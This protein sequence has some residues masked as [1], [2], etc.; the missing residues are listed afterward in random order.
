MA[1]KTGR[2]RTETTE[3]ASD[4]KIEGYGNITTGLI[5]W[6]EASCK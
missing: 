4:P 2:G 6:F 5:N 3:V 1:T